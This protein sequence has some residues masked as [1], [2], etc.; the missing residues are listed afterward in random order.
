VVL[1]SR[2]VAVR[3]VVV[4]RRP[5]IPQ[6]LLPFGV[7]VVDQRRTTRI[8][9]QVHGLSGIYSTYAGIYCHNTSGKKWETQYRPTPIELFPLQPR[10][11]KPN[12]YRSRAL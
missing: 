9:I 1:K 6:S 12:V 2:I 10:D 7:T 4:R 8:D 3:R 11:Y 5:P